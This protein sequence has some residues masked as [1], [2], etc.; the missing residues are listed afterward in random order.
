MF[1]GTSLTS[2]CAARALSLYEAEIPETSHIGELACRHFISLREGI[3]DL[4]TR[5][6]LPCV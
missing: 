4:G 2:L 5:L 6:A 1:K 3:E